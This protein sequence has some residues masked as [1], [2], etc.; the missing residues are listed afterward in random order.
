M[1][2]V[3]KE[4]QAWKEANETR[5]AT[6]GRSIADQHKAGGSIR[7][8]VEQAEIMRAVEQSNADKLTQFAGLARQI[9]DAAHQGKEIAGLVERLSVLRTLEIGPALK[10]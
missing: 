2:H 1:P 6:L 9:G 3:S 5:W 4:E 7:Q 10:A 8:L